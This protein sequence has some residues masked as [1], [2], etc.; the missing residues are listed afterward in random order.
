MTQGENISPQFETVTDEEGTVW[1]FETNVGARLRLV[2]AL[3]KR[4]PLANS[5]AYIHAKTGRAI[6]REP[7]G[8]APDGSLYGSGQGVSPQWSLWAANYIDKLEAALEAWETYTSNVIILG[9][10]DVQEEAAKQGKDI[11]PETAQSVLQLARKWD[12]PVDGIK[13]LVRYAAPV[14]HDEQERLGAYADKQRAHANAIAAAV[15]D[16]LEKRK[17]RRAK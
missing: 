7:R 5:S 1:H 12:N 11:T 3:A 16:E 14:P 8:V 10:D 15:A 6:R 17:K 9:A 4:E 2:E 13:A